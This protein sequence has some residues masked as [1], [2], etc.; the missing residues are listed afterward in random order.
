[1]AIILELSLP[2]ESF[3]LGDVLEA[4]P[5]TK[6]ELDQVV[7]TGGRKLPYLWVET[8]DFEQFEEYAQDAPNVAD[9]EAV[10]TAGDKRL[11][12]LRWQGRVE[13]FTTGVVEA[14]GTI[15]AGRA[16][17]TCWEFR[18]RF[19]DRSH[20]KAFQSHCVET[21]TPLDL[22]KV[23]DLSQGSARKEYG[24][25]EKQYVALQLAY[26]RG[27]FREPRGADLADLGS[28]LDISPRAVSYRLRRGV[29]S[30]VEHSID[31]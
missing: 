12:Q 5:G 26:E 27:Y 18:L 19:P 15:L 7:P 22:S 28:E 25:T 14:Q 8:T 6:L 4:V 31:P 1:M 13:N 10:E 20:A 9:L 11:Y 17:S 16:S 24:L 21:E 3:A 2:A 30:L 29:S 23:Y